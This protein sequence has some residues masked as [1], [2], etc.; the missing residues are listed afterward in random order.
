MAALMA[1]AQVASAGQISNI[2]QKQIDQAVKTSTTDTTSEDGDSDIFFLRGPIEEEIHH[3]KVDTY[4][5]SLKLINII[6]YP[7]HL[8]LCA[9]EFS[10]ERIKP[11]SLS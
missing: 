5:P 6:S 3:T 4:K 2:A 10:F 7:H 8:H 11:P 9:Q 1:W